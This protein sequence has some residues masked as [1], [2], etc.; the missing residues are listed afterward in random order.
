MLH[1]KRKLPRSSACQLPLEGERKKESSGEITPDT[2]FITKLERLFGEA[3]MEISQLAA[4][5]FR[6]TK[7]Q[8]S[9]LEAVRAFRVKLAVHKTTLQTW[10]ERSK[11]V[12]VKIV[13]FVSVR[14]GTS[15]AV[16]LTATVRRALVE[17]SIS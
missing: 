3:Q 16:F 10:N 2:T 7:I 5:L 4:D 1:K 12:Q 15:I 14:N 8:L 9:S 17:K 11:T 13:C 6:G